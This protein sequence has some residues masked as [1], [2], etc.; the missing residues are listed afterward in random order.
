MQCDDVAKLLP[1]AVEHG[2]AVEVSVQRHI[3]SCLRCQAELARYRACCAGLQLLRTRYLEPSARAARADAR[4]D[5]RGGRAPGRPLDP[6]RSSPRLRR[7]HRR[8]RG[9]RHRGDGGDDRAPLPAAR[10]VPPELTAQLP[11]AAPGPS[12][13]RRH[14]PRETPDTAAILAVSARPKRPEGSSSIGRAPVS[15]TGGCGFESLLPC[16]EHEQD[17]DAVSMNRQTKRMMQKQGPDKPGQPQQRQARPAPVQRDKVGPREFFARGQGRAP[18][19]RLAQPQGSRQLHD[20]RAHRGRRDDGAHLRL[21]LRVVEVRALPLRLTPWTTSKHLSIPPSHAPHDA[22]DTPTRRPRAARVRRAR[23]ARRHA[24]GSPT[25]RDRHRRSSGSTAP[26]ASAE[27]SS[28]S[29]RSWSVAGRR[30]D[31]ADAELLAVVEDDDDRRRARR[32]PASRAPTTGPATGSSCTR[33][34]ATR[35]R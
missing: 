19:G 7:C 26:T 22:D 32:H 2:A 8:C 18:Q 31:L 24:A 23:W 20:H 33:T 9:R 16:S 17:G 34:R 35:T 3:E 10:P 12:P 5:R 1:A 6:L 21:R 13:A 4:R 15:K 14:P 27:E 28:R 11:S 25:S 30:V 29:S